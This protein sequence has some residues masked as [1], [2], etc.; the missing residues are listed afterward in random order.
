MVSNKPWTISFTAYSKWVTCPKSFDLYYNKKIRPIH[1][2]AH[3]IFGSAV[4]KALNSLLENPD[5]IDAALFAGDF[6]LGKLIGSNIIVTKADW[7]H[8]LITDRTSKG[9]L[10]KLSEYGY[11]GNDPLALATHLF[12]KEDSELTP[13]QVNAKKY[14]AFCSMSEKM[15]LIVDSFKRHIIPKIGELHSVQT[16]VKRGVFDFEATFTKFGRCVVDNKTSS[17]PYEDDAIMWSVQLAGYGAARAMYIVFNKQ[18]RKNRTKVCSV[19]GNNGTGGRHKTCDKVTDG[20]RCNGEWTEE[21]CPEIIPQILVDDIPESTRKLV[22]D[23]YNDVEKMI[24]LG[25]FPRNL[26]ACHNQYGRPCEYRELC[27]HNKMDGLKNES[28]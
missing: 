6:E 24:A 27:W 22:E 4:D 7:D 11:K 13:N 12:S 18:V 16:K 26:Q 1:S 2:P 20:T 28:K 14:L 10:D 8:E 17:R 3:L 9:M 15:G 5:D 23:A 19:C 25:V 21:I